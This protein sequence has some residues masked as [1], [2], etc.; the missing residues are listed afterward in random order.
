MLALDLIGCIQGMFSGCVT[1][2]MCLQKVIP[3]DSV[4]PHLPSPLPVADSI[5][6]SITKLLSQF[7]QS[8]SV[9]CISAAHFSMQFLF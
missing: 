1:S 3:Q 5:S 6:F 2:Q 8:L 7:T 4:F 9:I